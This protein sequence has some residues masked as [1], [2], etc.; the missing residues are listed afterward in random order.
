MLND[1]L[2]R[3]RL[4]N[5]RVRLLLGEVLAD[6]FPRKLLRE[7]AFVFYDAVSA[8]DML[9]KRLHALVPQGTEVQLQIRK[10][11]YA[12]ICELRY[13]RYI[14]DDAVLTL[15]DHLQNIC[16]GYLVLG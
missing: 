13:V 4:R 7:R 5:E 15:V 9:Q 14:E 3:E 8:D 12:G 2:G 10:M 16:F 6:K 11:N 1:N